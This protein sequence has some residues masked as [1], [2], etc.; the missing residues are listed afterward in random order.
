[1]SPVVPGWGWAVDGMPPHGEP[2]TRPGFRE[3]GLGAPGGE[4]YQWGPTG[5]SH[6]GGKGARG[7]GGKGARGRRVVREGSGL[8]C[9]FGDA[10]FEVG[11]APV[12][13][14]QVRAGGL[15]SLVEGAVVGGELAD[16][17]FEGCWTSP[18]PGT[19]FREQGLGDAGDL[20]LACRVAS[21]DTGDHAYRDRSPEHVPQRLLPAS[22]RDGGAAA[23]RLGLHSR[24]IW[25][26]GEPSPCV[27]RWT[28]VSVSWDVNAGQDRCATT[29]L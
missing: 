2:V 28:A 9:R 12:L 13:E 17:L 20:R 3:P 10:G 14:A 26:F 8:R 7:Q 5:T 19:V 11:D 16:A 23:D 27:I 6:A 24:S 25:W 21:V 1:M 18:I 4:L 15:E 29:S 22:D